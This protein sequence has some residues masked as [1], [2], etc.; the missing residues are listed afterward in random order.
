MLTRSVLRLGI[1]NAPL[2]NGAQFMQQARCQ[3]GQVLKTGT[4]AME[5]LTTTPSG[6]RSGNVW[7]GA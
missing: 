6:G 5:W 2:I 7:Q 3:T 4:E 1:A